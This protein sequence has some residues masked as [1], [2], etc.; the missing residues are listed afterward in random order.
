MQVVV[1][2]AATMGRLVDVPAG[3]SG[4]QRGRGLLGA[5]KP[6]QIVYLLKRSSNAK[7]KGGGAAQKRGPKGQGPENGS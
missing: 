1:A 3:A 5:T 2:V 4:T 6:T 7:K